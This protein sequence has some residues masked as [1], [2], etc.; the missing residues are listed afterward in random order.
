MNMKL[1][2]GILLIVVG[3]VS[4][5]Y[6]AI[7]YTQKEEVLDVGPITVTADTEKR[8]PI[9]PIVGVALV[10]GGILLVAVSRK[11]V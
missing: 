1:M 7:T 10:A 2:L 11:K 9:A 5:G 6:Q 4:F 8:I 3:V